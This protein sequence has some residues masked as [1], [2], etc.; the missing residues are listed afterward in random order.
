MLSNYTD[1]RVFSYELIPQTA[2]VARAVSEVYPRGKHFV[3]ELGISNVSTVAFV[4]EDGDGSSGVHSKGGT[5]VKITTIDEEAK[6]LNF[7]VGFMKADVEGLEPEVILGALETI[8]RDRPVISM[9]IYHNSEFV[10]VPELL[11]SLGYELR[12]LFPAF[13]H[14]HYEATVIGIPPELESVCRS[15]DE[16]WVRNRSLRRK[17]TVARWLK[18]VFR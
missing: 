6:R 17:S 14:L 8:R 13:L 11:D 3:F 1:R 9:A 2:K 12:F 10:Y 16:R 5:A 18:R 4:T 15:D 7:T